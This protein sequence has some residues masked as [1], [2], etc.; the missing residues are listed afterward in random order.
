MQ[1]RLRDGSTLAF[2]YDALG[3]V[4]SRTPGGT[5]SYPYDYPVTYSYNLQGQVTQITRSGDGNTLTYGYG[6][7]GRLATV[8]QAFGS[9]SYQYDAAGNR[10]R[11]TWPDGMYVTYSYDYA[12]L[13]LTIAENGAT[14]GVGVLAAFTYDNLGRRTRVAYGN[15]TARNYAYDAISR[16]AG[17]QLAFPN[18]S[19]N[20]T[21]GGVGGVGTAISYNPA[22]QITS[23][24]RS[25][26]AYSWGG[27]INVNRAYTTNGLN[28]Y[29]ASG[30]VSLGYDSRGNLSTSGTSSYGYSKLNEMISAPGTALYYDPLS[31]LSE[32]D[33]STSTRFYYDGGQ[34]AA[35]V[36]NPA[37]TVLRRYV[38]MP[39]SDEAIIWYEGSGT[40]DR[41][42]LQGDER[43]SVIAVSD[44]AGNRIGLNSYDEFGIPASGNVGRFGYT[45]QAWYSEVGLYNYKSRWYSPTLGRFMQTDPVGYGDG[46]NWYNYAHG[47][48]INGIDPSGTTCAGG[49]T[50]D[51]G[52]YSGFCSDNPSDFVYASSGQ[53]LS[54]EDANNVLNG[55]VIAGIAQAG[56]SS[57]NNQN[58]LDWTP[59]DGGSTLPDFTGGGAIFPLISTWNSTA[60]TPSSSSTAPQSK[61]SSA[62][63]E[64][65]QVLN[66]SG[67]VAV[68]FGN[69]SLF[70]GIGGSLSVGY[71][72]NLA[73]GSNGFF[74]T[75]GG[76]LGL[77]AGVGMQGGIYSSMKNFQG[78]SW[79]ASAAVPSVS[80]SANFAADGTP[81]GITAGPGA[82]AGGSFS[83]G[84][85]SLFMCNYY[86]K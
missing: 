56:S 57:Q 21:I 20:H 84:Y 49:G 50:W 14:S 85:T 13:P 1:R 30:S 76:G 16:L 46:L 32:Y 39:G 31:R 24:A 69:G 52:N 12:N 27:A 45:G 77:Q 10:T 54:A 79:S 82:K 37:G 66:Q 33:A 80:G 15:G 6:A 74:A 83:A 2:A 63:S 65:S 17:V 28:Q 75:P 61:Q 67:P 5:L 60:P 36:S 38:T 55:A 11:M 18:A 41:R 35:E 62:P 25:N 19:Y 72:R 34:I 81:V 64:C 3:R 51:G 8:G 70:A 73:T 44:S 26:A 47:D 9:L 68:D 43:G 4:V 23:I 29:T 53:P 7:L 59:S 48:P 42:F 86:G 22:S 78:F 40:A 58:F 71:F